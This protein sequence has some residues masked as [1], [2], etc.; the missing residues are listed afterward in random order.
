MAFVNV[1]QLSCAHAVLPRGR[2]LIH[3]LESMPWDV[4]RAA[5]AVVVFSA[6]SYP[7][8]RHTDKL[9]GIIWR[10]LEECRA[11]GKLNL[12]RRLPRRRH[13]RLVRLLE[14]CW[15]LPGEVD[16]CHSDTAVRKSGKAID[17]APLQLG[18]LVWLI[19]GNTPALRSLV[20]KNSNWVAWLRRL[21]Q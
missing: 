14:S 17:D 20:S 9:L 19:V 18:D 13:L 1:I 10:T 16:R 4:R 21:V 5:G 12:I 3:P 6:W 8:K 15:K 2:I 7:V 11:G